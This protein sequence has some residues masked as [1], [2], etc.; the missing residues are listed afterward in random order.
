MKIIFSCICSQSNMKKDI[1]VIFQCLISTNYLQSTEPESKLSKNTF[2][3][4]CTSIT[5]MFIMHIWFFAWESHS[6]RKV[7]FFHLI[8][9]LLQNST[10]LNT[11]PVCF[12]QLKVYSAANYFKG[13]PITILR[14]AN[15]TALMFTRHI[16]CSI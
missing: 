7:M 16:M 10:H 2:L 3:A 1:A 9:L 4:S 5:P 13:S 6:K 11:F 8:W 14:R 12:S 15:N